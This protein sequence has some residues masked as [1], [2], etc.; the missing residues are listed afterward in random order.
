MCIWLAK[1][2][3]AYQYWGVYSGWAWH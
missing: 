2:D 1:E 3:R